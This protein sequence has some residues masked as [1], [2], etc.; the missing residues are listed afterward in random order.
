MIGDSCNT[1]GVQN[2]CEWVMAGIWG[3][4]TEDLQGS[5]AVTDSAY[6]HSWTLP[7]H[8]LRRTLF[9]NATCLVMPP[10]ETGAAFSEGY[11]VILLVRRK[12]PDLMIFAL[13]NKKLVFLS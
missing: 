8:Q 3:Q 2:P 7:S 13:Q 10:P 4:T 6:K 1:E 5:F 9:S 11:R 12:R